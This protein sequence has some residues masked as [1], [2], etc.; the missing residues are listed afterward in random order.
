MNRCFEKNEK[1]REKTRDS[2][3]ISIGSARGY[4]SR[5]RKLFDITAKPQILK[6]GQNWSEWALRT[7]LLY[8]K[9]PRGRLSGDDVN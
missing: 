1:M 6:Q 9:R 8:Q 2:L 7:V 4:Q 3:T 5:D